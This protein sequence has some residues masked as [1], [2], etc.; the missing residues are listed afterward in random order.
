MYSLALASCYSGD[1]TKYVNSG[2]VLAM[3]IPVGVSLAVGF[4]KQETTM[5]AEILFTA[6]PAVLCLI[7]FLLFFGVVATRGFD[8]AFERMERAKQVQKD[9]KDGEGTPL[10]KE[11]GKAEVT[12][13]DEENEGWF[14]PTLRICLPVMG[15]THTLTAGFVPLMQVVADL[16]YAHILMLVRFSAEFVGRLCSHCFG[17]YFGAK[18]MLY[19]TIIRVILAVALVYEAFNLTDLKTSDTLKISYAIQVFLFYLMGNYVNS[20]TMAIAVNARPKDT[21]TVAYVMVLLTYIPNVVSLII[22]VSLLQ[23]SGVA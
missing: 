7:S 9:S 11:E 18:A 16:A 1:A 12:N 8:F 5:T 14:G 22:V 2:M 6:I 21:L 13:D 10:I 15:M 19:I 23:Y 20:E 3:L 4:Y 17:E